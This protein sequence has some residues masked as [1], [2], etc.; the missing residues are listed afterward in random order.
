MGFQRDKARL[1]KVAPASSNRS[2]GG[3]D[4]S[5]KAFD[6]KS[7]VGSSAS[8]QAGTQVN[9]IEASKRNRGSRPDVKAG[10]AAAQGEASDTRILGFRR[11]I[12][13][14]MSTQEI[15]R[16]TGSLPSEGA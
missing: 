5:A 6:A 7:C 8:R 2:R 11:G 1:A 9:A 13:A 12:G 14:G 4:K 3:G 16:N 10:K 15:R